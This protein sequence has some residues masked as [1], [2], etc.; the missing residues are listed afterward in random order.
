MDQVHIQSVLREHGG[1]PICPLNGRDSP[2]GEI[3]LQP[4]RLRVRGGAQPIKVDMNQRKPTTIL[5]DQHKGRAT[6]RSRR[7]AKAGGN[8]PDQGG[9]AGAQIPDQREH[10]SSHKRGA[11]GFTKHLCFRTR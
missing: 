11:D 3:L 7:Y 5:V 2:A 6:D 4:N 1:K 10:F 9:F 8:S